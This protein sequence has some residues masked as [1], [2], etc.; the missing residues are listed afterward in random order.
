[1]PGMSCVA[2]YKCAYTTLTSEVQ[3]QQET[4][5][6]S[7][8]GHHKPHTS[9]PVSPVLQYSSNQLTCVVTKSL[10]LLSSTQQG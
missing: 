9:L 2:H 8:V 6:A 1:M 3:A 5:Q 4:V 10:L 7:L